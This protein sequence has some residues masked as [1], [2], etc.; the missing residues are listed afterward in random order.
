MRDRQGVA[1][2]SLPAVWPA[3]DTE[4]SVLGT[5]LHQTAITNLRTAI[6]EAAALAT[7]PGDPPRWHA[8]SQ[9]MISGFQHPDGSPY[10]TFPD[11]FVYPHGWDPLRGSLNVA[12]D[13]PPQ[14]IIEVL[15]DT[16][17]ENDLDQRDGKGYSYRAAGV[18]E[19][20]TLDPA[21]TFQPEQGRGWQLAG[22]R[23]VPWRRDEAGRWRS[24]ELPLLFGLEGAQVAVFDTDG[25]RLL[26]EGEIERTVREQAAR[27]QSEIGERRWAEAQLAEE[28]LR[29]EALARLEVAH[30]E[31][32]AR[33]RR[34]L[35][36]LER[37]R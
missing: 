6:N 32:L 16:T 31:E 25:R 18:R 34:R 4:E 3:D 17:H 30:A 9:T 12:L 13:G 11:V 26:R 21:G 28:R 23:Y 35:E 1:L 24:R 7:A 5:D 14:L 27:L 8:G 20:L 15:S 2:A 10:T 36:E 19:Y 29:A 37:D 33:L 22:R